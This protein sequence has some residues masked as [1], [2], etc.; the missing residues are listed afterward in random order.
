MFACT[1]ILKDFRM[2]HTCWTRRLVIGVAVVLVSCG[3]PIQ[4]NNRTPQPSGT[5]LIVATDGTAP[6]E[7]T[8]VPP[9]EQA[10]APAEQTSAPADVAITPVEVVVVTPR[11]IATPTGDERWAAFVSNR[12]AFESP[13]RMSTL[14]PSPLLWLDPRNGQVIEI[15]LLNGDFVATATMNLTSDNSKAYEV[16]YRINQDYG[17][18]SISEAVAM[19]MRDAGYAASVRAFVV[20]ND[21]IIEIR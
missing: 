9:A 19:R 3:Q 13:M 20:A 5:P 18:T 1:R 14:A 16:E 4:I 11:L 6:A 2:T 17:L 15:G 7:A 8:T 10:T 12:S 21:N